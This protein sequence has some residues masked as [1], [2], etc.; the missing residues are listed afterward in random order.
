[1]NYILTPLS[2]NTV[3]FSYSQTMNNEKMNFIQKMM[4]EN[5]MKRWMKALET[6]ILNKRRTGNV[7]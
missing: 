4:F 3:E 7:G 1:M 6:V 5:K 2:E